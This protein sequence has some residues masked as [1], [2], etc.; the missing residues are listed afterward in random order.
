M[1]AL[2]AVTV[3]PVA[4]VVFC[5]LHGT[6]TPAMCMVFVC[7]VVGCRPSPPSVM[8]AVEMCIAAILL[9]R[10]TAHSRGCTV[11]ASP[12]GPPVQAAIAQQPH[13][14]LPSRNH[15]HPAAYAR[16]QSPLGGE[17]ENEC[18]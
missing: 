10:R 1:P 11:H 17:L 14:W 6:G 13:V 3:P 7:L 4:G 12:L 5:A 18:I 8:Y 15:T 9:S 16:L 2:A